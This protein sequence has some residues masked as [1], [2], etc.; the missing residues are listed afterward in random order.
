MRLL[1]GGILLVVTSVACAAPRP[2]LGQ[3]AVIEPNCAPVANATSRGYHGLAVAG[4]YLWWNAGARAYKTDLTDPRRPQT[5]QMSG[6]SANN[7]CFISNFTVVDGVP[8]ITPIFGPYILVG[9]V[10][11]PTL[12]P[13]T[14]AFHRLSATY[15]ALL[16]GGVEFLDVSDPSQ[17]QT[18]ALFEIDAIAWAAQAGTV[19]A[20]TAF[21]YGDGEL[22]TV[23][24]SDPTTASIAARVPIQV[25]PWDSAYIAAQRDQDLA[26]L[27]GTSYPR[28]AIRWYRL[29]SDF[30][31]VDY[32]GEVQLGVGGPNSLPW[33]AAFSGD[34]LLV[35]AYGRLVGTLVLRL[36]AEV[37][38]VEHAEIPFPGVRMP[39]LIRVDEERGLAFVSGDVIQVLDLSVIT[40]GV[41]RWP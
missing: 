20:T 39:Q 37:G 21:R 5:F 7:T 33:G 38:L 27:V 25:V 23:D 19:F 24:A 3:L 29:S 16:Q 13:A 35:P 12:G 14:L 30:K 18:V 1:A 2:P 36:D 32:R 31:T 22:L 9:E 17:P 8:Y 4:S 28:S 41:A 10:S 15:L 34:Y 26:L 11:V 6:N 40:D